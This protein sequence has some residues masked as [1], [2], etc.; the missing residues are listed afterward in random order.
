MDRLFATGPL[1]VA[2]GFH[3]QV[4]QPPA[5]WTAPIAYPDLQE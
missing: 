2:L 4:A 5:P 3:G 1:V